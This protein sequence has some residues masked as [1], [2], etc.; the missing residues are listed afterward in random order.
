LQVG[1]YKYGHPNA[2]FPE[3]RIAA[4]GELDS[5]KLLSK[6]YRK[7]QLAKMIRQALTGHPS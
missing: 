5:V 6:P 4:D 3:N 7:S 1:I 2:G